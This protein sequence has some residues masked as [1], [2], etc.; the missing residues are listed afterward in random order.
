[1]SSPPGAKVGR[2]IF[3]SQNSI[4]KA[5]RESIKY[6]QKVAR[7]IVARKRMNRRIKNTRL[8]P[9]ETRCARLRTAEFL[10]AC[11]LAAFWRICQQLKIHSMLNVNQLTCA[12]VPLH[13]QIQSSVTINCQT[14][15]FPLNLHRLKQHV[16]GMVFRKSRI[17]LLLPGTTPKR[18]R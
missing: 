1:M 7:V 11:C 10:P 4:A 3:S 13:N 8:T 6:N 18:R 17:R 9:K 5:G 14:K 16:T 12:M 15:D 2:P